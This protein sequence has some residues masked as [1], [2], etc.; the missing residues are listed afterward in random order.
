[1]VLLTM[2]GWAMEP[3]TSPDEDFDPPESGDTQAKELVPHG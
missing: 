2:F 1:L 3:A